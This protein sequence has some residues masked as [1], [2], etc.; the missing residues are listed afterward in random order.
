[1]NEKLPS[2]PACPLR[3]RRGECAA[4]RA[5]AKGR[6]TAAMALLR[7]EALVSRRRGWRVRGS[8]R[9]SGAR[10]CLREGGPGLRGSQGRG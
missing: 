6:Q 7:G 9:G 3:P 8:L 1:M 10:G 5:P 4:G 2:A